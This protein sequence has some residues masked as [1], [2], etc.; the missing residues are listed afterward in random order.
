M[1]TWIAFF[2]GI[3]V[4]GHNRLS[5]TSLVALLHRLGCE[6]VRTYIQSGNA[7]FR[8]DA[9]RPDEIEAKIAAAISKAHGFEP[10]VLVMTVKELDKAI[11]ANPF[12]KAVDNHKSLHFYFLSEPVQ[13]PN[14]AA[15][16]AAKAANEAFAI[17]KEVFYLHSPGGIGKSKLAE[18]VE[19]LLGVAAT[20]RNWRTVCAV[21]DL[22]ADD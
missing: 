6:Q 14:L 7:V 20:A 1:T 22:V 10:R 19:K 21:R 11:A 15:L 5:M 9:R 3:N 17:A 12:P 4:G 8:C 18:R 16:N 13:R 2:R